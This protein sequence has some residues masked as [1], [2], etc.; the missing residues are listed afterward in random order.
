MDTLKILDVEF[1]IITLAELNNY[2]IR[3]PNFQRELEEERIVS[4]VSF[5]KTQVALSRS[6]LMVNTLTFTTYENISFDKIGFESSFLIDGQH[7]LAALK[8]VYEE[9]KSSLGFVRVNIQMIKV[10]GVDGSM[11]CYHAI[12]QSKPVAV[13]EHYFDVDRPK[14]LACHFRNR[15][16]S[17]FSDKENQQ[18][19][20]LNINKLVDMLTSD[21]TVVSHLTDNELLIK[22]YDFNT[23]L[24][25]QPLL[26]FKTHKR[27]SDDTL[28]KAKK[29]AM[30]KG[31]LLLGM[32]GSFS[33]TYIM[34]CLG[35]IIETKVEL[36]LDQREKLWYDKVGN[37][38]TS[39]CPACGISITVNKFEVAHNIAVAKGGTD[40]IENLRISCGPCNRECSVQIFD[41]FCKQ[42]QEK[43]IKVI[44]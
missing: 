17:M 28:A 36:N 30:E 6:K 12:N 3:L 42:K 26:F 13:T 19:P 1:K 35:G 27:Q 18:I 33:W 32:V 37:V 34:A 14:W 2:K 24:G 16:P 7:R 9:S 8:R 38:L 29:K 40:A 23:L 39:Q 5:I 31:G 15:F 21:F 4:I 41:E 10:N 20:H 44:N 43:S 11:F 22:L 25:S